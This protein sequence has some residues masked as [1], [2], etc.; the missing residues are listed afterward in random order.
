MNIHLDVNEQDI[1]TTLIAIDVQDGHLFI[2]HFN[3]G[4]IVNMIN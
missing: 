2:D 1:V 4:E 3:Y